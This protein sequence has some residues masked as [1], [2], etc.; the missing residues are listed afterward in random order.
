M[1]M[2]DETMFSGKI[3]LV[4]GASRGL[5]YGIMTG[6]LKCGACVIANYCRDSEQTVGVFRELQEQFGGNVVPFRADIS[7]PDEVKVMFGMIKQKFG[8]LDILVNNAGIVK[9]SMLLMMSENNW[10]DVI[11]VNLKGA[12]LCCK[13]AL[14]MM[15]KEN[16]GVILNVS[17]V[18][19]CRAAV[20]QSNYAS[21]KAGV[22]MLTKVLAKEYGRYTIRFNAIAPGFIRTDMTEKLPKNIQE[23]YLKNI[24]LSRFGEVIEVESVA[25]FLCSDYASYINGQCLK[26]DGGLDI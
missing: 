6:F 12:F 1:A 9:D 2:F 8:R 3:V 11:N 25:L 14:W 17:S 4:T 21:S 13:Q 20:G 24:P 10:D 23:E 18:S 5:G 15:T 22:I 7:K 16:R 19:G 26:I